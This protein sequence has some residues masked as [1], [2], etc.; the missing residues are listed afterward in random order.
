MVV[1]LRFHDPNLST[2]ISLIHNIMNIKKLYKSRSKLF[3][4][5]SIFKSSKNLQIDS[6]VIVLEVFA[7]YFH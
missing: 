6:I 4:H 1:C 7:T 5:T 3:L 2:P